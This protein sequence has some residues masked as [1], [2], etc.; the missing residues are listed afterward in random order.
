M[1]QVDD[2]EMNNKLLT[3][4]STQLEAFPSSFNLAN[5]TSVPPLPSDVFTASRAAVWINSLWFLSLIFSLSAAFFGIRVRQWLREYMQWNAAL[6]HPRENVY[7][8][9]VRFEALETWKVLGSISLIPGLLELALVF[10]VSGIVIFLW[11]LN[12]TVAIVVT[13]ATSVFLTI[14]SITTILPAFLKRCPYKSPTAWAC[15]LLCGVVSNTIAFGKRIRARAVEIGGPKF[16]LDV[17]LQAWR[18]T[19]FGAGQLGIGGGETSKED[20][21]RQSG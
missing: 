19:T 3:R 9:Q 11:T 15:V 1:L 13:I 17:H 4:I 16:R 7:V 12:H 10:F 14:A 5:S 18:E 6:A 8:R 21:Y 20:L 2:S